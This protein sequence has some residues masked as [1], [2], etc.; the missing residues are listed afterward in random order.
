MDMDQIREKLRRMRL[1]LEAPY[2]KAK[3]VGD[4]AEMDRLVAIAAEID[5][6][7]TDAALMSLGQLAQELIAI[8]A[9]IDGHKQKAKAAVSLTAPLAKLKKS[10]QDIFDQTSEEALSAPTIAT[11]ALDSPVAAKGPAPSIDDGRLML[12]DAHMI[13][14]WRRSVFPIDDSRITVFGLRGCRP[15]AFAGTGMGPDHEIIMTPV[16]YQVMKCTLGHWQ[17]GKGLAVFPGSTVPYGA[18]VTAKKSANGVGVNQMGRGRYARYTAGWHKRSEGAGGHWALRQDCPITIQRTG[19]D[20]DY[21]LSDRWEVGRIA[22]DNIHCA[23]HMGTDGNPADAK[24]SSAGCQTIAGTVIKGKADSASG[25]YKLFIAPFSDA[26]GHQKEAQYALFDAEEAQ[27][28]I[29]TRCEGKTVILRFGSVGPLV[30]GL[31]RA[32][33]RAGDM[34]SVDGD[35]GPSTFR[36]VTDFQT[37]TFG[38]EADDGIVGPGTAEALGMTLPAFDFDD[39]VAGG[40]GHK[41]PVGGP[42]PSTPTP[43]AAVAPGSPLAYG[44]VTKKKY[45]AAFNDKVIAIAGRLACDPNHLMAVMAFETGETFSPSVKNSAGSGATGLIQF[46]PSTAQALKTTTAKLAAMEAIEQLDYVERYF[47]MQVNGR[48]MPALSDL[49]M[50]VLWPAAVGKVDSHVLFEKTTGAK[51]KL[52]DQNSGLDIN[53]NGRITKAEAASKVHD[54]LVL[55]MKEN[56]FG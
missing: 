14:L 8:R 19:D 37:R 46:M 31:Q 49:Y 35:F 13:A 30:E 3:S 26:L 15:V 54:K 53:K 50:A 38:P 24:F 40:L 7:R 47:E 39:A 32:L 11:P 1:A 4:Q 12:S 44:R 23:F 48:P 43:V 29:R 6:L 25:P 22:G 45:G 17:P 21:D 18:T 55:G 33:N 51:G 28:M 5:Q 2:A 52:Y 9:K 27:M 10:I 36:A 20:S 56:R 42:K 34:L 16:D 41:G